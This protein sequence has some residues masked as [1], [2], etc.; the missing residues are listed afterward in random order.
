M[1]A[2]VKLEITEGDIAAQAGMDA[3]VNA[4]N[5]Q[6]R[7]GGGVAGVIHRGAGPGLEAECRLLAGCYRNALALAEANGIASI[8]F[9]AIS[10]GAFGYPL[11]AAAQVAMAAVVEAAPGLQSVRHIRLVVFGP[12]ARQAHQEALAACLG[13]T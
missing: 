5:A 13:Q 6:L 10:T 11:T 2:G 8:A 12:V 1:V 9:P 7:A 3:V 4:A